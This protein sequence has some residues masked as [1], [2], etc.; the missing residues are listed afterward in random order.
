MRKKF[1]DDELKAVKFRWEVCTV[2]LLLVLILTVI[3]QWNDKDKLKSFLMSMTDL[4]IVF[5]ALSLLGRF[6]PKVHHLSL[7][8]LVV[9]RAGW[10]MA[11][12]QMVINEVSPVNELFDYY[13]WSTFLLLRVVV[14][15][16]LLFLTQFNLYF[17]IIMPFIM[18]MQCVF[19]N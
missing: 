6:W 9:M 14:P 18:V 16:S 7:I 1:T 10:T 12:V 4:F 2:V 3:I 15:A 13:A 11:Q 19:I 5:I 8:I 17:Y